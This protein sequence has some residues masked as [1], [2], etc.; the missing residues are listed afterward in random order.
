[1]E[2]EEF[3]DFLDLDSR[4]LE[5]TRLLVFCGRSG[6][7]KS[8]AID[9]L[10]RVHPSFRG[11]DRKRLGGSPLDWSRLTPSPRPSLIVLDEIVRWRDLSPVARLLRDGNTVLAA[12]HLPPAGFAIFR[13]F[14]T[15]ACYRTDRQSAKLAR[16]LERSGLSFT[17]AA[18]EAYVRRYGSVYTEIEI[19]RERVPETSF[20]RM[21]RRFWK[22]HDVRPSPWAKERA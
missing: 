18:L 5:R 11:R 20:D 4:E 22:F 10:L 2:P 12:S 21:L 8:T 6:S 14:V 19:M 7:G 1:M 3:D 16:Y 13:L 17:P 9:H 15:V